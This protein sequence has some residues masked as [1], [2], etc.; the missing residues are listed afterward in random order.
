MAECSQDKCSQDECSSTTKCL[1][2]QIIPI[3]IV[4]CS[5]IILPPLVNKEIILSQ[6]RERTMPTGLRHRLNRKRDL[7]TYSN[8]NVPSSSKKDN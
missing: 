7:S 6:I 4:D 1:Q 3:E 5:I 8:N 2:K